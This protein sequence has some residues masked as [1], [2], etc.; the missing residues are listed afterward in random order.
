MIK[1]KSIFCCILIFIILFLSSCLRY[2]EKDYYK[3]LIKDNNIENLLYED[4]VYFFHY[5]AG[6]EDKVGMNYYFFSFDSYEEDFI[7][8]FE[9]SINS[10]SNEK[11]I[12]F[13]NEL[14]NKIKMHINDKYYEI[15]L[16]YRVDFT[17]AYI[18]SDFPMM[19]YIDTNELIIFEF[20][21]IR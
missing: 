11:S 15:P 17:K 10:F 19:Y 12:D 7:I 20:I 9:N 13:E 2:D 5:E 21:N 3:A 18:Y 1:K 6:F 8:Q 16:E 14:M 4:L